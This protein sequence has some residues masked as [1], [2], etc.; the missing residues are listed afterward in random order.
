[1]LFV[2]VLLLWCVYYV[3]MFFY[4][5]N[6]LYVYYAHL[7]PTFFFSIYLLLCSYVL[8]AGP[9]GIAPPAPPGDN[10]LWRF[11]PQTHR[12]SYTI[13]SDEQLVAVAAQLRNVADMY[14]LGNRLGT[15]PLA[16]MD[17]GFAHYN[18]YSL[19]RVC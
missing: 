5:Y 19:L 16:P 8:A 18:G 14:R 1:M 13:P 15:R 7:Y 12:A 2:V 10:S 3:A 6:M 11:P 17:N 9:G 4:Y